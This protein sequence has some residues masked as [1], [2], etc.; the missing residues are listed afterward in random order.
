MWYIISRVSHGDVVMKKIFEKSRKLLRN[1]LLTLGVGAVSLIFVACYGMPVDWEED[2]NK[3][4]T[5]TEIM[6]ED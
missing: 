4:D 5:S 2:P 3:E 1:V 6:E